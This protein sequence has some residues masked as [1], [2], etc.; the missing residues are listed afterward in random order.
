MVVLNKKTLILANFVNLVFCSF[1]VKRITFGKVY[2]RKR[3][4]EI[5]R[6]GEKMRELLVSRE[7]YRVAIISGKGYVE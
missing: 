4:R 2:V 5:E 7:N 6:E 1:T 3:E